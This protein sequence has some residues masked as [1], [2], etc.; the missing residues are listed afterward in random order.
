V[1]AHLFIS[2]AIYVNVVMHNSFVLYCKLWFE[3]QTARLL[4]NCF[5]G[6][7][8]LCHNTIPVCLFVCVFKP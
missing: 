8:P 3:C 4:V 2:I 7:F 5:I 1:D 6:V